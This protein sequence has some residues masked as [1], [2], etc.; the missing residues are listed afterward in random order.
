MILNIHSTLIMGRLGRYKGNLMTWVN[1]T[2]GKLIDR[3]AR[4]VSILLQEQG[5]SRSYEDVIFE[6]FE[7]LE[8]KNNQES[9]VMQTVKK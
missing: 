1:P 4:Y 7:S 3:A 5:I 6:L 9:I 2:N 8:L